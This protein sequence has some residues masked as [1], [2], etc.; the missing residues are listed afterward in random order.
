MKYLAIAA[1][2]SALLGAPAQAMVC[3]HGLVRTHVCLR[4]G[5]NYSPTG[6]PPYLTPGKCRRWVWR[7]APPPPVIK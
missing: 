6:R 1:L 4:R 3:R 5:P 7:C 2:F